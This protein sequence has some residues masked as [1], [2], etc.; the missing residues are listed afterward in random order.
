MRCAACSTE[1][2]DGFRFCGACGAALPEREE[3]ETR[4]TVTA[5]FADAV[6]STGIGERLDPEAVRGVM[7]RYFE[8]MKAVLERHGGTVE[9]FIGDAVVGVF[10]IPSLHEDDA[11]RAVRAAHEMREALGGLNDELQREH[12]VP[13]AIRI[14][15]NTG[16]VVAGD[17]SS[18]Q[19]FVV[20]DAVNVAA[21]LEQT[22]RAGEILI[23]EE[24]FRLARD[25]LRVEP[26]PVLDLKGKTAP[27][28]AYRLLEVIPG[29]P[30]FARRLDSPLVGRSA[31]LEQLERI[32]AR[33][34]E[35]PGC[36]LVTVVGE[37]GVGKSRLVTEFAAGVR[38]RARMIVTRCLAYGEGITFW[39]VAEAVREAAGIAAGDT[40][41]SA[42]DK[43]GAVLGEGEEAELAR[44]RVA[45]A[46]GLAVAAGDIQET[47][48]AIRRFLES[49]AAELPLVLIVEDIHWAEP[50]FLELVEYLVGFSRGEPILLVCTA[51]PELKEARPEW[52]GAGTTIT[53][54]PLSERESARLVDNLLGHAGLPDHVAGR[55]AETAGGNPL[56]V[57]EMLRMLIDD[58]RLVRD[59]GH[60]RSIGHLSPLE[61]PATIHALLA[62]R[63]DRLEGDER[64]VIQRAA[65]VGKVFYWG[66]VTSLA[67][68]DVRPRVGSCL[69]TL[70]RK[71]LV[72][73]HTSPFAGEDAFRFSHILVRDAA[74]DSISKRTR[75]ELHERFAS[76]LERAARER[77]A[78]HAELL[79]YHL[80]QAYRYLAELGPADARTVE[81]AERAA[82]ALAESGRSALSRGD[83]G[84]ATNLLSRAVNLLPK[85]DR[86][87][88]EILPDLFDALVA[89]G[90]VRKAEAVLEEGLGRPPA[91][92]EE[93]LSLRMRVR[94]MRL[95]LLT[96]PDARFA[97]SL[98][99]L[100]R[101]LPNLE[102]LGDE[103]ALADYWLA[104]S[105]L[106]QWV[107][108][109]ADSEAAFERGILYAERQ[110]LLRQRADALARLCWTIEEGPTPV[111]Q[112]LRR[113]EEVFD[114]ARGNRHV[115]AD[116]LQSRARF[117][118][119]LGRFDEARD[120]MA[121][122]R[123]IFQDLGMTTAIAT[124]ISLGISEI[125]LLAG[126]APA[127]EPEVRKGY[128]ILARTGSSGW[129][130]SR[131]AGLARALYA[132]GRYGEAMEFTEI[133]E[134]AAPADDLEPHIW[135]RAVR[136]KVLARRG[137][138]ER[139]EQLAREA[140]ELVARTD[141]IDRH[142]D[143]LMDLAE[144]LRL[145]GRSKEAEPVVEEALG[146]Y[147]RKEN[148]V[149]AERAR[150]VLEE[151][152]G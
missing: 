61:V 97:D 63:L 87:R 96:D 15:V 27:V 12:G 28:V 92:D 111:E 82:T 78:E 86:R 99:D 132:M 85:D 142:G 62:A 90:E 23:G 52:E 124:S 4:K 14:G 35:G 30:G 73:P 3:P 128:E 77:I 67:P 43:I 24:T 36:E 26:M 47:F 46:I 1:N 84:A 32:F 66:A 107:G 22:A 110:H 44:G 40:P 5:V 42:V 7:R 139:A 60:W 64:A 152:R 147:E 89:V 76:W 45:A 74:Y 55:I 25:A 119:M 69:Q 108:R 91:A 6:G 138:H 116:V 125:E 135:L 105:Y 57:E 11:L 109:M 118:A 81:L 117:Q 18:G 75:A 29:A 146:L 93:A 131:A 20:G 104:L 123:S 21:R 134:R 94:R 144:V 140:V 130:S 127:G 10:G 126:N 102:K 59:D 50:A 54:G 141:W 145:G 53:L 151:L 13:L 148:V 137:E 71:E 56:F 65:V 2:P 133:S 79:G 49:L 31:E 149:S 98:A 17:P 100:E 101:L 136:A 51:R 88:G 48:W 83:M 68:D 112:G 16:E 39:P 34:T 19:S 106:L 33:V 121:R 41:E 115:Q 37:A 143:T 80:E 70:I 114:R 120:L 8:E 38:A 95:S 150:R 9:K 103:V 58:G 129:L 113:L 72:R 122:A